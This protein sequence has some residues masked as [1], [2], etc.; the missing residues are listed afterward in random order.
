MRGE[1]LRLAGAGEVASPI[2]ELEVDVI[3]C[4]ASDPKMDLAL[5]VWIGGPI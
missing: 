4:F 1:G 2:F 3:A 5:L